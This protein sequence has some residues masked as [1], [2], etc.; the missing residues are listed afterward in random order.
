MRQI[1]RTV[2]VAC[3]M[4][5]VGRPWDG[6]TREFYEH[7]NVLGS[8]ACRHESR[9]GV[10]PS[11]K[12][13]TWNTRQRTAIAHS[14]GPRKASYASRSRSRTDARQSDVAICYDAVPLEDGVKWC[15]QQQSLFTCGL[16]PENSAPFAA[17]QATDPTRD[18]WALSSVEFCGGTHISNTRDAEAF[19]ITAEAAVA[20]GIRRV[21]AAGWLHEVGG[22][23]C[24]T[25][26]NFGAARE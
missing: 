25:L 8:S 24:A 1:G 26:S 7:G 4:R 2:S 19:V 17:S 15:R 18:E 11:G 6:P 13:P 10:K 12:S 3:H 20:K 16:F 23:P 5:E 21:S 9:S 22:L 14:G